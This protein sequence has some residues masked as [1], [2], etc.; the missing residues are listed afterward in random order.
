MKY[1]KDHYLIFLT[2]IEK[3][4]IPLIL[5]RLVSNVLMLEIDF[6]QVEKKSHVSSIFQYIEFLVRLNMFN[7]KIIKIN[8]SACLA[9][10]LQRIQYLSKNVHSNN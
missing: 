5:L 6:L 2:K 10:Y 7:L 3:Y 1:K 9:V 4:F 8:C